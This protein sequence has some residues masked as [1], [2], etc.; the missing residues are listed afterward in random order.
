[1]VGV[2]LTVIGL[3]R[4]IITLNPVSTLSEDLLAIDALFFM[5]SCILS[6]RALRVRGRRRMHRVE[7]IADGFFLLAL[8]LMVIICGFITY[9]LA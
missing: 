3:I 8:G 2:C 1:M 7:R 5:V 4:I 6:Y 9:A